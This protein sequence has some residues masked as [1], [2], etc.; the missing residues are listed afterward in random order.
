MKYDYF[1]HKLF[2]AHQTHTGNLTIRNG[3]T[4]HIEFLNTTKSY[5]THTPIPDQN[6]RQ[7]Q[8]IDGNLDM[9]NLSVFINGK[10]KTV[11]GNLFADGANRIHLS[12]LQSIHGDLHIDATTKFYADA[13][14]S[15]RGN[16]WARGA[17]NTTLDELQKI[18]GNL[19]VKNQSAVFIPKLARVEQTIFAE[20]VSELNLP[21]L[22]SAQTIYAINVAQ[23]E[24]P[25]WTNGNLY[26]SKQNTPNKINVGQSVKIVYGDYHLSDAMIQAAINTQ[27]A[28]Q[29]TSA[30][31]N[32]IGATDI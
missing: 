21:E 6:G 27:V 12:A 11:S 13:L 31:L 10:L 2:S 30:H 20:N 9:R 4:N 29:R 25:H 1:L 22:K 18:G 26:I 5:A 17:R 3:E 23:I 7:L 14:E 19:I 8:H 16:I 32:R 24:L 15:V 28:T